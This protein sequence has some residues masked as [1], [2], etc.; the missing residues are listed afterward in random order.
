[1]VVVPVME[2]ALGLERSRGVRLRL[3]LKLKLSLLITALLTTTVVLLSTALLY[4]AEQDLTAQMTRRALAIAE[5]LAASARSPLLTR[6]ELTL[7]LLVRD[8]TRDADVAYV[9]VADHRGI[10]RAHRDLGL[11]GKPLDRPAALAAPGDGALVQTYDSAEHGRLI[12][13]AVPLVFRK[14]RVGAL[15]LGFSQFAIE[16]AIA[17]ARRQTVVISAVMVVVGLAGALTLAALLARPIS[18]L[19]EG[20]RA[21]AGGRLDVALPV[22]SRDE[23]GALTASFNAMARS[24]REK[25][26]ITQAFARYVA[27]EVVDELLKDPGRLVLSGERR[28]V[29]VVFCDIRGFTPLAERLRPEEVVQLLNEF[30]ELMIAA[31]FRHE[32]TLDKFLGDGVMAVFGAPIHHA[33][34]SLRAVRTALAM[35]DGVEQLSARRVAAGKDPIAIGIGVSAGEA[36]AGTVGTQDRMEYTVIGDTVNLAARL[37]ARAKPMQI[38]ISERTHARVAPHVDARPLGGLKVRGKEDEIEVFELVAAR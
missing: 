2:A 38:L 31:T 30:Y 19:V 5:N 22:R 14:V 1:M 6:D 18:R 4:R 15:Y 25:E 21:V 9:I 29:T 28:E 11:V 7:T 3:P 24:L 32:G 26:M 23:L 13:V 12:D 35:R 8:A 27:R 20:T 17:R 34:H 16:Q 36:V 33:D 10:V 37:E